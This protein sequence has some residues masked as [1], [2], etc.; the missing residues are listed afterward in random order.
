MVAYRRTIWLM[1]AAVLTTWGVLKGLGF[2]LYHDFYWALN[3]DDGA[4]RRGLAGEIFSSLF[5]ELRP[6][7]AQ[8][9]VLSLH[10]VLLGG[11]LV[12]LLLMFREHL[13]RREDFFGLLSRVA[14]VAFLAS[15]FIYTLTMNAGMLD[16]LVFALALAAWSL[17][18]QGSGV[19]AI[20]IATVSFWVHE[21]AFF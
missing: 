13:D 5:V 3:Y 19:G 12:Y 16:I 15:P 4:I 17:A 18:R 7:L 10:R 14:F 21:T 1:V 2:T 11:I 8:M 9:L 20:I 6:E